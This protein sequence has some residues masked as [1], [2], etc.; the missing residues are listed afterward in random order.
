MPKNP[1]TD[2]NTVAKPGTGFDSEKVVPSQSNNVQNGSVP[3]E[4]ETYI[5]VDEGISS[6]KAF[7]I[8]VDKSHSRFQFLEAA[9]GSVIDS[10]IKER[11]QLNAILSATGLDGAGVVDFLVRAINKKRGAD[12][13]NHNLIH[14]N[15]IADAE[16]IDDLIDVSQ[17]A[18][19]F[20]VLF[21]ERQI[22][23]LDVIDEPVWRDQKCA[24]V[25]INDAA[26]F[27][28]GGHRALVALRL[29]L[30]MDDGLFNSVYNFQ[31]EPGIMEYMA[32]LPERA[33]RLRLS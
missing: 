29:A 28:P 10:F 22:A 14:A 2:L 16:L 4:S 30:H 27:L 6:D 18:E 17:S 15:S 26:R 11:P 19:T 23:R 32:Q 3:K 25:I 7:H 24:T 12:S 13:V 5:Q 31:G 8:N 33:D 21:G 1:T 20:S 9:A